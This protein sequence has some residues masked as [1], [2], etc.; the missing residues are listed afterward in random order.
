MYGKWGSSECGQLN[1][2]E[3]THTSKRFSKCDWKW[4][5]QFSVPTVALSRDACPLRGWEDFLSLGEADHTPDS[6]NLS[7]SFIESKKLLPLRLCTNDGLGPPNFSKIV[8]LYHIPNSHLD[9]HEVN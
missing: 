4:T 6:K 3:K 7:N 8:Y 1:R 2:K 5:M 9:F